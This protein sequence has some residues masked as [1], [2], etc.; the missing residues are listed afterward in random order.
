MS[1]ISVTERHADGLAR[2]AIRSWMDSA[3]K[4]VNKLAGMHLPE[5]ST[6]KGVK[7]QVRQMHKAMAPCAFYIMTSEHATKRGVLQVVVVP[8]TRVIDGTEHLTVESHVVLHSFGPPIFHSSEIL[9]VHPHALAR[10]FLR[11]QTTEMAPVGA[12]LQSMLGI[13][14]ALCIACNRLNLRQV[15]F[16]TLKGLFR[17]DVRMED[18]QTMIVAKTWIAHSTA[19][20]RD[21]AVVGDLAQAIQDWM[22]QAS[23]AETQMGL[24]FAA[25]QPPETLVQA[26]M[27]A[28]ALHPWLRESYVERRDHLTEIWEAARAQE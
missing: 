22:S 21:M 26:L 27:G 13:C 9:F 15:I 24:H 11:L 4:A 16:F 20:A 14:H 1:D 5:V 7:R 8:S 3:K 18:G 12:E 10:L 2:H 19:G 25:S 23:G 17:C 6:G 28:L